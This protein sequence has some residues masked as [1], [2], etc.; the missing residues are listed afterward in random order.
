MPNESAVFFLWGGESGADF[1]FIKE[2]ES[3]DYATS[4][5]RE[6]LVADLPD[7][8]PAELAGDG[9]I[10]CSGIRTAGFVVRPTD[11][12]AVYGFSVHGWYASEKSNSDEVSIADFYQLD[13][14]SW[15]ELSGKNIFGVNCQLY[16]GFIVCV[17]ALDTGRLDIEQFVI[18]YESAS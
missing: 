9:V 3:P 7:E 4:V 16:D 2:L 10:G 17:D 18:E 6:V 13:D 12:A 8:P 14:G 15:T 11:P 1:A 5:L